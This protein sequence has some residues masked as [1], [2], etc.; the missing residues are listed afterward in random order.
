M[1]VCVFSN[2]NH[3]LES[4]MYW[5]FAL[6]LKNAGHHVSCIGIGERTID[7]ISSENIHVYEFSN[8]IYSS[9]K[10]LN[11]AINLFV[12]LLF[13]NKFAQV[14][15]INNFDCI[16][17]FNL[18]S[19]LIADYLKKR[20]PKV[21]I[22]YAAVDPYMDT[23]KN[24]SER[25]IIMIPF[26]FL[27]AKWIL[28]KEKKIVSKANGVIITSD[29]LKDYYET[30]ISKSKIHIIYNYTNIE[31]PQKITE[32]DLK[33]YD[34]IYTGTVTRIRGAM[35]MVRAIALLKNRIPGVKLL[36]IGN[37]YG[38]NLRNEMDGFISKHDLSQNVIIKEEVSFQEIAKYYLKSRVGLGLYLPV[39]SNY[40]ILQLK[41][42][43]YMAYGLP[44]ICNNFGNIDKITQENQSGIS[45]NPLNCIEISK[46]MFSL[47]TDRQLY[48]ALSINAEEAFKKYRWLNIEP[49]F[50]KIFEK[51]D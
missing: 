24:F 5:K 14:L 43:E 8:T 10:W 30:A 22:V 33:E 26:A 7:Y 48:T 6:A 40:K 23:Y 31:L 46:A 32:Y 36:I 19:L 18:E 42:F 41:I 25:P 1:K 20:K 47:I 45:V 49:L 28:V 37:V 38:Q 27:Y 34:F 17:P 21:K 39:P 13:P 29:E 3:A 35:E 9:N 44:I 15:L 2:K 12:R 11:K 4:H 50:Q 16:V 51:L